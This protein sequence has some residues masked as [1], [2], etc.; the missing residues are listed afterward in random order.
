MSIK[1]NIVAS[2]ASQIYVTLV[3]I[4]ALPFYI[5]YMGAE[6]YG[7]VGF[8]TML[9]TWFA[10]LDLGLTPTIAR[11]TA[12]FRAGSYDNLSYRRLFRALS[13]IFLGIALMGGGLLF[14]LSDYLSTH[15]L[16]INNLDLNEVQFAIQIMA[17]SVALRWMTGLYRGVVT[18]SERLV[19]L[20]GFNSGIAS[21]RF[22]G[23][24]PVMWHFGATPTVFFQYQLLIALVEFFGLWFK[25]HQLLPKL[26]IAQKKI[27]G[28]SI[29]P[30][31][32]VL[33]FSLSIA[34]T[35][36]IWVFATQTDKLIM[37]NLLSLEDYGYFTLAVLVAGGIMMVSAPVSGALM[38]RMVKLDSEGKQDQLIQ[39]YRKSTQL[40]TVLAGSVAI[41]LATFSKPILYL[42]TG[43]QHIANVAAETLTFYAIGYGFLAVSA[44]P[45]YLQY[46]K[47][48]LK[49]HIVGSL[50]YITTLLPL[51]L[52]LTNHFGMQGAGYAWLIV[53]IVYFF[54]WTGYIHHIYLKGVHFSWLL[55]DVIQP[56][57]ISVIIAILLTKFVTIGTGK[58]NLLMILVI[59][60]VIVITICVASSSYLRSALFLIISRKYEKYKTT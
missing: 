43:D 46:A 20:S 14:L 49:L 13:V 15:W 29:K 28:W 5:K 31:R 7:L 59:K 2:Y 38:P 51:L 56:I 19:W 17:V 57:I 21:L 55:R 27:M 4:L 40:V 33:G 35:G 36:G 24:F 32:P 37:S 47:G 58:F 52:I 54:T 16:K 12:R 60:T 44:F 50:L 30:I 25:S 18:G 42:W 41:I 9:Q 8:F 1:K 23:I 39:L 22:L 26:D 3:G 34:L 53:N 48:K 11:E 45:Y 10:L 6:A